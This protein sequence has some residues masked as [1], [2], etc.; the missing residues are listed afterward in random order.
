MKFFERFTQNIFRHPEEDT[1]AD[2]QTALDHVESAVASATNAVNTV[3]TTIEQDHALL[4]KVSTPLKEL[5]KIAN[6]NVDPIWDTAVD[7]AKKLDADTGAAL[8]AANDT[9]DVFQRLGYTLKVFGH[10]VEGIWSTV[11]NAVKTHLN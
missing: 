11:T 3:F 9:V 5:L 2:E 6:F 10:D 4:D 1:M 7:V 8:A